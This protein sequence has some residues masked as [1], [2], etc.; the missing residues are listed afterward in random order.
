VLHGSRGFL[1]TALITSQGLSC[2]T[3]PMA[4]YWSD[5]LGRKRHPL[6]DAKCYFNSQKA[7]EWIDDWNARGNLESL[8]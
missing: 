5:L 1:L 4:G 3:I 8:N 6:G 2:L 7:A